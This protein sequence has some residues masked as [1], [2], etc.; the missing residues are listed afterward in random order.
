ML[1]AAIYVRQWSADRAQK[2]RNTFK[3]SKN[4]NGAGGGGR[5]AIAT[6]ISSE[7]Q[8]CGQDKPITIHMHIHERTDNCDPIFSASPTT[9]AFKNDE[10]RFS[11]PTTIKLRTGSLYNVVL[12]V[13]E[14][15]QTLAYVVLGG[16]TYNCFKTFA[17]AADNSRVYGFVWSTHRVCETRRKHRSVLPCVLRLQGYRELSVNLSVKFYAQDENCRCYS[18]EPLSAIRLEGTFGRKTVLNSISVG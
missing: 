5:R 11:Q 8:Q 1:S 13:E 17:R 12:E 6:Y 2:L 14:S 7:S 15:E 16:K 9:V 3:K 10:T 18:G 4:K